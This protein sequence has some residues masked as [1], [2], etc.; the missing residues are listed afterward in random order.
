[1]KQAAAWR[2]FLG[3]P[4]PRDEDTGALLAKS[5]A[6]AAYDVGDATQRKRILGRTLL[7]FVDIFADV[8][9]ADNPSHGET[10]EGCIC[11]LLGAAAPPPLRLS[12]DRDEV[13]VVRC[14]P[15]PQEAMSTSLTN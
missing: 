4:P 15:S 12:D 10:G 5:H 9:R 6:S 3:G 13:L 11:A 1:M 2:T 14:T 7:A 8:R